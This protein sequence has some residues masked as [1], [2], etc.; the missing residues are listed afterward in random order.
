MPRIKAGL[1]TADGLPSEYIN[2]LAARFKEDG[3]DL[4][5]QPIKT[6]RASIDLK[7]DPWTRLDQHFH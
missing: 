6:E 1:D 2:E 3:L 4:V 5:S 7:L